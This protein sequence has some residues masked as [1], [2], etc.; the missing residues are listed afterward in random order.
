MSIRVWKMNL[1]SKNALIPLKVPMHSRNI[2][3]LVLWCCRAQMGITCSL[4]WRSLGNQSFC[5][6]DWRANPF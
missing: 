6:K 5:Y 2:R 3:S 1:I 4:V